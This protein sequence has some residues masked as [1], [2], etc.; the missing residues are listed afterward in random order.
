MNETLGVI[1]TLG[2]YRAVDDILKARLKTLGVS[3]YRFA[4]DS[5]ALPN[6]PFQPH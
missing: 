4:V 1:L 3:E 6:I 5:S 2:E